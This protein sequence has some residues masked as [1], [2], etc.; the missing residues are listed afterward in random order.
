MGMISS[1]NIDLLVI[2]SFQLML[3]AYLRRQML[4]YKQLC[5]KQ[6]VSICLLELD[7]IE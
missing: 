1:P 2:L 3:R 7:C 4:C 6:I 5:Y